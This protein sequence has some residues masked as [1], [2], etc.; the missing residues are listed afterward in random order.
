MRVLIIAWASVLCLG[1]QLRGL[2]GGRVGVALHA[3]LLGG[4]V[5]LR[6]GRS[7]GHGLGIVQAGLGEL[8]RPPLGGCAI[9]RLLHLGVA[10]GDRML[11][12]ALLLDE[13]LLAL[14]FGAAYHLALRDFM[15]GLEH[16]LRRLVPLGVGHR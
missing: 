16:L 8:V 11:P 6:G 3:T 9:R 1:A 12:V 5:L 4:G 10:S 7:G 15:A 14:G 13:S 2:T